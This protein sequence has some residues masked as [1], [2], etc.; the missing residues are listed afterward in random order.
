MIFKVRLRARVYGWLH[1]NS[2]EVLYA[3]RPVA[4]TGACIAIAKR[5][6]ADDT[7]AERMKMRR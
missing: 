7:A 3:R 5:R 6:D 2:C 4:C 1:Q